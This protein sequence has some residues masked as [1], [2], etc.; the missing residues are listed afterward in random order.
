MK[1]LQPKQPEPRCSGCSLMTRAEC[2][3]VDCP[4]RKPPT[5]DFDPRGYRPCQG[6]FVATRRR[7]EES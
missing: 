1:P 7:K 2:A 4:N 5:V 6:G 3:R